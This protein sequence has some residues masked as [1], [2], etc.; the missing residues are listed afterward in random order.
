MDNYTYQ[1]PA[2]TCTAFNMG[3]WQ[4]HQLHSHAH[5][6]HGKSPVPH[7]AFSCQLSPTVVEEIDNLLVDSP[8]LTLWKRRLDST[9]LYPLYYFVITFSVL[10]TVHTDY[11]T[12]STEK[13]DKSTPGIHLPD[14]KIPIGSAKSAE[15]LLDQCHRHLISSLSA[16][17][18]LQARDSP[19]RQY[20]TSIIFKHDYRT[21]DR[22]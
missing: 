19:T 7:F 9:S 21:M 8:K 1:N 3:T 12:K 6:C 22:D 11:E 5:S 14:I 4:K 13:Y 18:Y 2:H 17:R 15:H 10:T 16:L 20:S